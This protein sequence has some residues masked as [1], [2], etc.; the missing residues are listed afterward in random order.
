MKYWPLPFWIAH[1]GAGV[2]APENTLA[3][4]RCG[5]AYGYRAFECDVTLSADGVPFVFHDTVLER[6]TNQHGNVHALSWQQL[7]NL[8]TGSWHSA[9]FAGERIPS[10]EEVA[11][12]C[13]AQHCGLNIELKPGPGQ[14]HFTGEVVARAAAQLWKNVQCLPSAPITPGPAAF[15]RGVKEEGILLSSFDMS[16]LQG[17]RQAAA[18]LPRALLLDKL[19]PGWLSHA[20]NLDCMAVV[21]DY[22]LLE[23]STIQSI[24]ACGMRCLAYTVNDPETVAELIQAGIDGLIT[25]AVD[26][27]SPA[28]K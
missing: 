18:H 9:G 14:G 27:F 2:L 25:D 5:Y 3:A 6:T 7:R 13:T 4:F 1:R 21:C 28:S 16:A 26:R 15:E 10:L 22:R 24:H 11:Q 12:Y 23:P 20:I 19:H 17:A 8:D